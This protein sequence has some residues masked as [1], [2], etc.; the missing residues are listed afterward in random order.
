MLPL[1]PLLVMALLYGLLAMHGLGGATTADDHAGRAHGSGQ[2]HSTGS[3][4]HSAHG[5]AAD[6]T[7]AA[8]S[9]PEAA[10]ANPARTPVS[11][12]PGYASNSAHSAMRSAAGDVQAAGHVHTDTALRATHGFRLLPEHQHA[13][14]CECGGAD[15]H[16]AHAD[17]TCAASGISGA[18]AMDA[19]AAVTAVGPR[20]VTGL[21]GRCPD[22]GG[23]RA[24][25]S[26]HRLQLLR[27]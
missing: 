4:H 22:A 2:S 7:P 19:V 9:E 23:E 16:P 27:I 6:S 25:P 24:P 1:L 10:S 11:A 12:P 13:D 26:L 20:P 15:G 18:P 3:A 14:E 8:A 5:W 17:A 21:E